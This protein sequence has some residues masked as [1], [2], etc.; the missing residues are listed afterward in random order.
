[1]NLNSRRRLSQSRLETLSWTNITHLVTST[2]CVIKPN[3][4]QFNYYQQSFIKFQSP[5]GDYLETIRYDIQKE[6]KENYIDQLRE[7]V[8][9]LQSLC[10]KVTQEVELPPAAIAGLADLLFRMQGVIPNR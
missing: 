2:P 7:Q 6:L 3:S 10:E 5:E 9:L 4:S 8:V 1:L